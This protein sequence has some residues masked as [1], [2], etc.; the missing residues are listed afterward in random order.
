MGGGGGKG[1]VT[2]YVWV[3]W[4]EYSLK[5]MLYFKGCNSVIKCKDDQLLKPEIRARKMVNGNVTSK[6]LDKLTSRSHNTESAD[7]N[8]CLKQD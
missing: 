4:K 7:V 2:S 6:R 8:L 1:I 5:E 3:H